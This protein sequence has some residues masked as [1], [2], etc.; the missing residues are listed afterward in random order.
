MDTSQ[1]LTKIGL[2]STQLTG[3]SFGIGT[4]LLV[5]HKIFPHAQDI[6]LVGIGYVIIA[7]VIN[8]LVFLFLFYLFITNPFNRGY[9]I[10]KMFIMLA[11]IPIAVFYFLLV[12]NNSLIF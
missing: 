3:V 12:I 6:I 11:N 8:L 4:L 10:G 1:Y 5:L 9:F 7:F 2:F